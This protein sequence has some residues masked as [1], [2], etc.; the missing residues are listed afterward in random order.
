M[1][2][3]EPDAGKLILDEE[4]HSDPIVRKLR[5]ADAVL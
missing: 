2:V 3:L 1:G 4:M 5:V